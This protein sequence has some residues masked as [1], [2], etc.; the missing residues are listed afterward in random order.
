M[1][2]LMWDVHGDYADSSPHVGSAEYP[3]CFARDFSEASR[4]HDRRMVGRADH[5]HLLPFG[6]RL[7]RTMRSFG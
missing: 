7:G 1:R 5:D 4:L 6:A 2:V 3:H